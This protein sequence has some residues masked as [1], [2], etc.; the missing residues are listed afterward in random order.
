MLTIGWYGH[1]GWVGKPTL[2]GRVL[3]GKVSKRDRVLVV[4][5]LDHDSVYDHIVLGELTSVYLC[6]D[7]TSEV[8]IVARMRLDVVQLA[9]V[10]LEAGA[11]LYP[12]INVD[13]DGFVNPTI[14]GIST[15]TSPAWV[16]LDYIVW[17][18]EKLYEPLG[19]SRIH[20]G[21]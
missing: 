6:D 17:C 7:G 15:G 10:E 14:V 12:Q 8:P 13:R 20:N 2:D 21:Q 1:I 19:E 11:R 3:E 5:P 4:Y 16:G 9:R 18:P